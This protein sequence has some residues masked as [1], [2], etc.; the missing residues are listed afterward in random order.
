MHKAAQLG[1]TD[2]VQFLVND[3]HIHPRRVEP[4]G[5]GNSPAGIL[6]SFSLFLIPFFYFLFFGP[7]SST[8]HTLAPGRVEWREQQLKATYISSLRPHTLVAEGLIHW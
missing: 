1:H 5:E 2:L 7:F 8:C 4:D 6:F 3:L